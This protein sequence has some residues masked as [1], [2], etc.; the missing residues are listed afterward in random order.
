MIRFTVNFA[1]I[2]NFSFSSFFFFFLLFSFKLYHANGK[3]EDTKI[4]FK[5]CNA[6]IAELCENIKYSLLVDEKRAAE[7]IDFKEIAN[8][9][10]FDFFFQIF[11]FFFFFN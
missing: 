9:A 11:I 8:H 10:K 6:A 3:I 2:F 7:I 4:I 5:Q 1:I